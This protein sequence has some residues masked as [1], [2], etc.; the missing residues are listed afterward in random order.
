MFGTQI[1]KIAAVGMEII[2]KGIPVSAP[3]KLFAQSLENTTKYCPA[4]FQR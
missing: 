1:A 2:H 4:P 3:K